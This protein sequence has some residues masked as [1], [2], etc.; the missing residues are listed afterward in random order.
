MGGAGAADYNMDL[1]ITTDTTSPVYYP[2]VR[3]A[4]QTHPSISLVT[5]GAL[6]TRDVDAVQRE[7]KTC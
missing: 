3:G 5:K 2:D 7:S 6:V 4:L 1:R